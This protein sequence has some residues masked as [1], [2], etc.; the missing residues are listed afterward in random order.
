MAVW[1]LAGVVLAAVAFVVTLTRCRSLE[2]RLLGGLHTHPE[3][4]YWVSGCQGC[5]DERTHLHGG[6][7]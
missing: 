3:C 6:R 2:L 5:D 4:G 7:T 1:M